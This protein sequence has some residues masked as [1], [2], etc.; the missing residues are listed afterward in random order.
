M[1]NSLRAYCIHMTG[2]SISIL[3]ESC[4]EFSQHP[5]ILLKYSVQHFSSIIYFTSGIKV[6]LILNVSKSDKG[7]FVKNATCHVNKSFSYMW[8]SS[9]YRFLKH[10]VHSFIYFAFHIIYTDVEPVNTNSM[11]C[12]CYK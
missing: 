3:E 7:C 5:T 6:T 12:I 4:T 2:H 10:S 9:E 8:R 1:A 11:H